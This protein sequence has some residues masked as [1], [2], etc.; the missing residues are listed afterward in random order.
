MILPDLDALTEEEIHEL[1][2]ELNQRVAFIVYYVGEKGD[3]LASK[4]EEMAVLGWGC[5][6]F[7]N[8]MAIFA[9]VR[10]RKAS[11]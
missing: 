11:Q 7:V 6:K 10:P 1:L 3:R 9:K 4:S 5:F 2:R 8:G